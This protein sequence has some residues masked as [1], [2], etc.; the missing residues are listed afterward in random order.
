M[1]QWHLQSEHELGTG[2][3]DWSAIK[4]EN[5]A[6]QPDRLRNDLRDGIAGRCRWN[7]LAGTGQISFKSELLQ[8][9]VMS[10]GQLRATSAANT[11]KISGMA[12]RRCA[13]KRQIHR[14]VLDRHRKAQLYGSCAVLPAGTTRPQMHCTAVEVKHPR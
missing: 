14:G 3:V 5:F 4:F 13:Q 8:R 9:L 2:G 10:C 7:H 1:L 11:R 6:E 12:S